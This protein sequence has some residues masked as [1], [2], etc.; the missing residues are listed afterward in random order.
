MFSPHR[1]SEP[2]R[3]LLALFCALFLLLA[4][5]FSSTAQTA[6]LLSQVRKIY[7]GSF[8]TDSRAEAARSSLLHRL[9][10]GHEAV[11]AGSPSEADAVLRGEAR[12]WT[13]G[14]TTLNPRSHGPVEPVLEGLLSA[15]LVGKDN[16][17]LWSYLVTPSKFP[18]PNVVDDLAHQLSAKLLAAIRGGAQ[19]SSIA[20]NPGELQAT[21]KGA[22]AT[23]PAPLYQKWFEMFEEDHHAVYITYAPLGSAEGIRELK[24]QEIDFGGSEMPLSGEP[25][26]DASRHFKQIPMVLGA[27]VPIYNVSGVRQTLNFTP[28]ILAKI[29]LG[30]IKQWNAPEIAR[31]NR[32]VSLPEAEITVVHRSDGSGTTFVWSDFLSKVSAE[33]KRSVGSGVTVSWPAGVGAERN[34]GVAS[35][36]QQTPNSI[37]Y[38]EFIYAVQH[39]LSFG[40]VRNSAGEFVRASIASVTAA[41]QASET[42]DADFRVSITDSPGKSS[43]PIVSYTWLLF[44]DPI[45]DPRKRAAL[46]E[47]LRWALTSGQKSCSALGYAPLPPDVAKRALQSV[48]AIDHPAGANTGRL[49]SSAEAAGK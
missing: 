25:E 3:R 31:A 39:E 36:V 10:T 6:T 41:A 8:G 38:V 48:E 4:H 44:R 5:P 13:I 23:F 47:L 18:W 45:D 12:I 32:G 16:Q 14:Y 28:E 22:G 35:T 27:V 33:W 40:A 49:A 42:P 29:Y 24:Q 34:E 46:V 15:E 20:S 19:E 37:G 43:Y 11:V 30:K 2:S 21:L 1:K 26:A 17:I 7:V 9:Q